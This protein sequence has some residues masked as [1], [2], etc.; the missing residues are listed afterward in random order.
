MISRPGIRSGEPAVVLAPMEGVTDHTMRELLTECGGF[1]LCVSEFLRVSQEV[2]PAHVFRRDVPELSAGA[3]TKSGVPVQV[4]LLGGDPGRVAES[5]AVAVREGAWGIDLNFGCPAPTVNRHD[6]G[7]TLLKYPDRLEA[8]VRAVRERLPREIPVSAKLRLGWEDVQ[9]IHRNAEAAVKGGAA[10]ITIHGRTRMQAYRPPAYWEPIGE[11]KR[12]LGDYP[13]VANG[14]L[15][16]YEDF[17]RCREITGCEHFMIGRGALCDPLLAKRVAATLAGNPDPAKVAWPEV[18]ARFAQLG[19][20]HGGEAGPAYVVRRI[21][22]W[23]K[24]ASM[25]KPTPWFEDVKRLGTWS[26]IESVLARC[27]TGIQPGIL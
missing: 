21:K 3:R 11:V 10:W 19:N 18:L 25:L 23:G 9:D 7:A 4:Q 27:D 8:I 15:G 5:A 12:A 1:S 16:S 24:L 13:V 26:E 6:G 22:Q 2:L 20:A 14:D 17:L